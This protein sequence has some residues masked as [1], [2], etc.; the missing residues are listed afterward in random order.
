MSRV[1]HSGTYVLLCQT[2]FLG[3]LPHLVMTVIV[4]TGGHLADYLRKSG[5]MTTTMVRKL[6]NCGGFGMEALFFIVVAYSTSASGATTALTFG[7]AFSGFAISGA[8]R[9]S[10]MRN[11]AHHFF[12]HS[13]FSLDEGFHAKGATAPHSAARS[14]SPIALRRPAIPHPLNFS[15]T[16]LEPHSDWPS[17]R[18][19]PLPSLADRL[20]TEYH[21][22]S[23]VSPAI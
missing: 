20:P 16:A 7:V 8:L 9:S 6:F 3:S 11:Y 10:T 19:P 15:S 23:P 14:D 18:S 13:D 2:G 4:P 5:I 22:K 21:C 17:P 12:F 1:S